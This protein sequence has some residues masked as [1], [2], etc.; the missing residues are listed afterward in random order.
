[1]VMKKTFPIAQLT[2]LVSFSLLLII[3]CK[4]ETSDSGLTPQKEEEIATLSAQAQ[5]ENELVFNDIVDNVIGVN[6]EVG[7]AGI[8]VFGRTSAGITGG[9]E[10]GMDSLTCYTV[11]VV[12][13]NAPDLFPVK[14]TVDFG[15][16]CTGKDGHVRYGKIITTYTGRLTVPGKSA[17]AT[18]EGFKLD[19]ITV[20]GSFTI[21]NSTA[22]GSNQRQFSI[23]VTEAKLT[24]PSGAYSQWSSHRVITQVEGNGTPELALDDIFTIKGSAQGKV[25]HG[26]DVFAWHAEIMEPLR[27]K[28]LCH[29]IS[30]GIIKVWRETL[31]SNSQWAATL[32]YGNGDCDFLATLTVNGVTHEVKLP[33]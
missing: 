32:N 27:K 13:L 20:Q 4:K 26:T 9:R 7:M 24:K 25:K 30:K 3:G 15:G 5:T 33:H 8:G 10:S 1:M 14:I 17:T 31:S 21:T 18:F 22:A 11:S 12:R 6:N 19:S 29:W 16:G 23:D 28:F 2:A